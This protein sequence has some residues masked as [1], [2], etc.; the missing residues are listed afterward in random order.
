MKTN[1]LSTS[2]LNEHDKYAIKSLAQKLKAE[3]NLS[4]KLDPQIFAG[5]EGHYR[6]IL[7][8]ENSELVGYLVAASFDGITAEYTVLATQDV[9]FHRM[10]DEAIKLSTMRGITTHLLLIDENDALVRQQ[11]KKRGFTLRF[12]ERR[13]LLNASKATFAVDTSITLRRA[14]AKD[15]QTIASFD[16]EEELSVLEVDLADFKLA[17]MDGEVVG[18]IRVEKQ[19]GLMGLYAFAVRKDL[20]GNGIGRRVL[21][22]VIASIPHFQCAQIYLEV[23][24]ENAPALH[25]YESVGFETLATFGYYECN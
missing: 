24:V 17:L 19:D 12:S 7:H 5:N 10:M 2:Q 13:M 21:T 4:F 3:Q 15:A 20:R 11:A 22:S 16:D 14:E 18:R 23:A 6:H 25:L 8:T 9:S 1:F